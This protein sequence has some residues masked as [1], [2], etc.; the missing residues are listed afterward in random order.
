MGVT[1]SNRAVKEFYF[2]QAIR[3][4]NLNTKILEK[5]EI[6]AWSSKYTV[7]E[8]S[9]IIR[10]AV[11]RNFIFGEGFNMGRGEQK[12]AWPDDT[13]DSATTFGIFTLKFCILVQKLLT[14]GTSSLVFGELEWKDLT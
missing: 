12:S 11:A 9:F 6:K 1:R 5:E 14:H 13:S 7:K 3:T 4:N 2:K 10:R 8:A